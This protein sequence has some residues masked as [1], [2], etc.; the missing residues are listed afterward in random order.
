MHNM[1]AIPVHFNMEHKN[2]VAN[3]KHMLEYNGGT[4]AIHPRFNKL[5]S[6]LR[7]AIENGEGYMDKEA[8]SHDDLFDSFRLSLMFWSQTASSSL[9]CRH[10]LENCRRCYRRRFFGHLVHQRALRYCLR[11]GS[12]KQCSG[13]IHFQGRTRCHR[14][15]LVRLPGFFHIH[16]SSC[17]HVIDVVTCY[18]G[19]D[20]STNSTVASGLH[21]T[22]SALPT[23]HS[24]LIVHCHMQL[25]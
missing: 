3:C 15:L 14:S 8:T 22:G 23:H 18:T 11:L 4:V 1:F 2:I 9:N 12:E 20:Y 19:V 10:Y 17:D 5:N 6:A 13:T 21:N 16:I 24:L 7:T 25:M